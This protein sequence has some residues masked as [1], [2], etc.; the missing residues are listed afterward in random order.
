MQSPNQRY[1][2]ELD[3]LRACAALLVLLFHSAHAGWNSAGHSGWIVT[4]WPPLAV[5]LEGHTG[6]GL[7]MTLSGFVLARAALGRNVSYGQFLKNR[8]LR[9]LPLAGLLT[10]F[11]LYGSK[12]INLS[13]AMAPFLLLYNTPARFTDMTHLSDS[14]WAVSVEFQFYLIAPFLFAF[15][16]KRGLW[17]FLLPAIALMLILRLIV[18]APHW[19]DGP[20]M[21]SITYYSIVGRMNQFLIGIGLAWLYPRFQDA[22]PRIG[23]LLLIVA[24]LGIV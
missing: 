9:I 16:S 19:G 21:F 8:V 5:L 15:V 20:E 7:F 14:L 23:V 3:E 24:S 2:P 13:N 17:G 22:G 18:L 4:R 1:V 11:G 10:I 6:V 12:D